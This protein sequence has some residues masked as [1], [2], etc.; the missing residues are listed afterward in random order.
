MKAIAQWAIF[1]AVVTLCL[2][3][4]AYAVAI[5]PGGWSPIS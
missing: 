5:S 4:L 1:W 3:A 2:A